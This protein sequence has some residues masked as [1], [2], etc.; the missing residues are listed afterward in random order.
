MVVPA[1]FQRRI[2]RDR[3]QERLTPRF[4]SGAEHRPL[5]PVVRWFLRVRGES[6]LS[7]CY[8]LLR[9]VFGCTVEAHVSDREARTA[10]DE[11]VHGIPVAV[12]GCPVYAGTTEDALGIDRCTPIQQ[13]LDDL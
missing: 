4:S 11:E 10:C 9:P 2:G 8:P 1:H 5:Q 6:R 3:G 12:D 13:V 7:P